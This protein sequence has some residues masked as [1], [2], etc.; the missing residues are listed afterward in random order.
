MM[1]QKRKGAVRRA[2][3]PA[4]VLRKL[5]KGEIEALTLAEVL[6]ADFSMLLC[7]AFPDLD[8]ALVARMRES[9]R[10]WVGRTR[11]AGELLHE[12]YGAKAWRK[13]LGHAS[14]QVRGWG[15]MALAAAPEL[16]VEERFAQVRPFADDANAGVR[17][18][19]WIAL[20]PHV[21]AGLKQSLRALRPWVLDGNP[22]I[23]RFASEI[24][25]PRGVWCAHLQELRKDPSPGLVLLESLYADPSRSV[26][27][28]VANWLSDASKDN[29][30]FARQVCKL[31]AQQSPSKETAYIC[32]RAQRTLNK[33]S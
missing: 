8:S 10:G 26:Q 7:S 16:S 27:N 4:V 6:A 31:W 21:A 13:T 22:N 2:D 18:V 12:A 15:A 20:R 33:K 25:R 30:A 28:P 17:E 9:E 19:A 5:N 23:R 29:P 14:D 11:L 1:S 32:K 24:T 3:I